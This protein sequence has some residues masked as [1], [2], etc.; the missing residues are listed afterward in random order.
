MDETQISVYIPAL[1][2]KIF[3]FRLEV[4][5]ILDIKFSENEIKWIRKDNNSE[6]TLRKYMKI[7]GKI[8]IRKN[9]HIWN[10]K[11]GI[12]LETPNFSDFLLK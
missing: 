12:Q 11:I 4:D 5:G 9:R 1:N 2:R 7:V 10:Q 6:F 8:V 3:K